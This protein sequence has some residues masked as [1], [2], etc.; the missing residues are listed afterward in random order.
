MHSQAA[1]SSLP[2]CEHC[3][4]VQPNSLGVVMSA[5]VNLLDKLGSMLFVNL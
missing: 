3:L 1:T 4:M 2:V 5:H